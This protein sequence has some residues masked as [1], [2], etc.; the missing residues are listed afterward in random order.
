MLAK[1]N[2]ALGLMPLALAVG[3]AGCTPAGPQALLN[4]RQLLAKGD[5][6]GA[7]EQF[8]L[9]TSLMASNAQAWNYLGVAAHQAGQGTQAVAAYQQA[10]RLNRDLVE[11]RFNLGCLLEDQG[12]LAAAQ[13]AFGACTVLRPGF[14]EAWVRRGRV[15]YR[16]KDTA[17]AESSLREALRQNARNAEAWNALGLVQLQRNRARDAAQSFAT[18]LRESPGHPAA[19]LNLAIVTQQQLNDRPTALALYRQYLQLT[20]RRPDWEAV[21]A[22]VLALQPPPTNPPPAIV[23]TPDPTLPTNRPVV[24]AIEPPAR[25]VSNAKPEVAAP[26]AVPKAVGTA[27]NPPPEVVRLPPETVIRATPEA[28]PISNPPAAR[29]APTTNAVAAKSSAPATTD[30]RGFFSRVFGKDSK[31]VTRPTPLPPERTNEAT[32][33]ALPAGPTA[34]FPR[35]EYLSPSR[36]VAGNTR[37]SERLLAQGRR[38]Q[39]SR[40]FAEAVQSYRAAVAADPANFDAQFALGFGAYQLRS[41]KL[42]MWAWEHALAIHPDSSDARYNFALVLRAANYVPDAARELE[43]VLRA[44]DSMTKAH[45]TLGNIYAEQLKDPARARLHYRRVLDL[46]PS[47]PRGAE[48]RQWLV[49][50]KP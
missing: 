37:E 13:E 30:N 31:P 46:E 25:P 3:M 47:H 12:K 49:N 24:K 48:I 8:R 26:P 10:I 1:K 22:I 39:D 50:N 14:T 35:Y 33:A 44:D 16:L 34:G 11:A 28:A 36:P 45:L 43:K 32:A 29:P 4:G 38:E 18:A 23:R 41:Y 27:T 17:A 19:L 9:A 42:S 2:L 21:N 15:E 20:P 5:A 6:A 7:V 40:K